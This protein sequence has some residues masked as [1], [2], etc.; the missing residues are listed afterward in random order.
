MTASERSTDAT[1]AQPPHY[2]D[3]HAQIRP[4]KTALICEDRSLTYAELNVRARKIANALG[5]LGVKAVN[6]VAAMTYNSLEPLDIAG[7]LSKMNA[8][9]VLLTYRLREHELAYIRN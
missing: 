1:P 2:L 8:I 6:R 5:K 9:V 4:N 3:A 7:A